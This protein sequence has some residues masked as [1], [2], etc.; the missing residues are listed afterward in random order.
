MGGSRPDEAG[1]NDPLPGLER[2]AHAPGRLE[3]AAERSLAALL[4][5]GQVTEATHALPMELIRALARAVDRGVADGK[6][7]AAAMAAAQLREA[8]VLLPQ[9]S[10]DTG[11]DEWARLAR[12]LREAA[13][14]ER[15]RL[16]R[17]RAGVQ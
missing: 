11:E 4:E 15:E 2:P 13:Q 5:A 14:I 17:E 10:D 6:A 7:S 12:E 16:A 9:A 3:A 8:W 1:G